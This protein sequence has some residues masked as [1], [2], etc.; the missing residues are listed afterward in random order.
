MGS[1]DICVDGSTMPFLKLQ[2]GSMWLD[3]DCAEIH[4]AIWRYWHSKEDFTDQDL[5]Q[6]AIAAE[7]YV[8]VM[9]EKPYPRERVAEIRR[10]VSAR[11][12]Q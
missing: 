11:R 9:T 2:S 3:P 5:R 10:L 1:R 8:R 6:I 12:R 4:S 7:E